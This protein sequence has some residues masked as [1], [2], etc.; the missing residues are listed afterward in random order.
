MQQ[1][2]ASAALALLIGVVSMAIR[3]GQYQNETG[4][5]YDSDK[6]LFEFKD[7]AWAISDTVWLIVVVRAKM[8][9]S[10]D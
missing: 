8:Q 6:N 4:V 3:L 7:A 2:F 10:D 5:S 9:V 1:V